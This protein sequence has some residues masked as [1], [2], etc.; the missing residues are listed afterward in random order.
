[1][2]TKHSTIWVFAEIMKQSGTMGELCARFGN[3]PQTLC[4][5]MKTLRELGLIYTCG[6]RPN[7]KRAGWWV[8]V[9]GAQTTPFELPD[10]PKPGEP[11][12][13]YKKPAEF[14]S[15]LR[16]HVRAPYPFYPWLEG[17]PDGLRWVEAALRNQP[18][19]QEAGL[20][21]AGRA[22]AEGLDP[23]SLAESQQD[24]PP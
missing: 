5:T 3:T 1:M 10:A 16:G 22:G 11:R 9:W 8:A 7:E 2:A 4:R 19:G 23:A 15:S 6:W 12:P 20:G 14:R 13:R 21:P 24:L 17:A 18:G